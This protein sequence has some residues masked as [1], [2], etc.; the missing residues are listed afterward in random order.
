[1]DGDRFFTQKQRRLMP[2]A[3]LYN[4]SYWE[5]FHRMGDSII[6]G[7]SHTWTYEEFKTYWTWFPA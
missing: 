7:N 6:C 2:I 4:A 3:A 5:G 1:M